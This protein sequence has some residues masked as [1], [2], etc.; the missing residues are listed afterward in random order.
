[1]DVYQKQQFIQD[2]APVRANIAAFV[3]VYENLMIQTRGNLITLEAMLRQMMKMKENARIDEEDG[4]SIVFHAGTTIANLEVA[5]NH[6]QSTLGSLE[7]KAAAGRL[8]AT[9]LD[10]VSHVVALIPLADD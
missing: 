7:Q 10:R 4:F 5:I 3:D 6:Q 2:M 9:V 1:M 8:T